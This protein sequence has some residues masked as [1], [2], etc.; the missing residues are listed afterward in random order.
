MIISLW[1]RH[2]FLI[3]KNTQRKDGAWLKTLITNFNIMKKYVK[4]SLTDRNVDELLTLGDSV[5]TKMDGNLTFPT[6]PVVIATFKTAVS[7][8]RTFHTAAVSTRSIVDFGLERAQAVDV[9]DMLRTLGNYVDMIAKGDGNVI[10]SAGM[11]ASKTPEKNPA[12][13][14]ISEFVAK[15]TGIPGTALIQWK[16]PKYAKYFRVFMSTDP[17]NGPWQ[18]LDTIST[19]KLMV[20]NLASGK[21]FYFKVVPVGTAGVGPDSEIAEAMAA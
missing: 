20:Q 14:Q 7:T 19:R 12:P 9:E 18:L 6:P 13:M 21:K 8:L 4:L 5:G 3:L 11:P 2:V 10:I 16:R 17:M 15:Y 1:K